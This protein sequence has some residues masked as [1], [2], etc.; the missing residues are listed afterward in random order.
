MSS[1]RKITLQPLQN[2][3]EETNLQKILFEKQK[4]EDYE[5]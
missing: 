4:S 2:I 1:L 5:K 3:H